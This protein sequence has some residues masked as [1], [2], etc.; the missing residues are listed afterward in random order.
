MLNEWN[1]GK[2]KPI[3]SLT[4]TKM[5]K[6]KAEVGCICRRELSCHMTEDLPTSQS[7][8]RQPLTCR[9]LQWRQCQSSLSAS[10]GSGYLPAEEEDRTE[11]LLKPQREQLPAPKVGSALG[12]PPNLIQLLKNYTPN[13][14]PQRK[15]TF[16]CN[17]PS[18][19]T[20]GCESCRSQVCL[21]L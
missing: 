1:K 12:P 9:E 16:R 10:Q 4:T 15:W 7:L 17:T 21:S 5:S 3:E 19:P 13:R 2:C 14:H 8:E 18:L 6:S 20:V 11:R